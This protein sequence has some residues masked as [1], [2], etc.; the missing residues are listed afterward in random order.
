MEN[1]LFIKQG[2]KGN[3]VNKNKG[4]TLI[5]LIAVVV[6]L[7]ILATIGTGFVVK[8]ME[9]YQ[10]TQSRAL[11]VNTARQAL[12]RMTRQLRMALPNSVRILNGGSCIE[13]MPIAAGG[14]YFNPVAD[15][16]NGVSP[17]A[18][19]PASQV[20]VDFGTARHLVIGANQPT[21]IY[22]AV[23]A[24]RETY[25]GYAGNALQIATTKTWQRNSMSKRYYLLDNPLAF[26]V[27]GSEL[28]FYGNLSMTDT[29]P[30]GAFDILA[31][32]ITTS[33][34]FSLAA[35]SENR[36]TRVNVAL[37]ISSSG[38][39]V[40]YTQGVFIRNVP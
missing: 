30:A 31:K 28:R 23:G 16:S 9:G 1:F 12:E 17:V 33:T 18:N 20:T 39:T 15:G 7:A 4:F 26:C 29:P 37:G 27:V 14:N 11:L 13:F 22:G 3:K 5:E 34:P 38:E 40:T 24:S 8:T 36:S 35:G 19:I 10:R 32:G 2:R 6:I 25:N 21:E